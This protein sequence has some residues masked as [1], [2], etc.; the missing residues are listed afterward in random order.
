MSEAQPDAVTKCPFA[1]RWGA[2]GASTRIEHRQ[3]LMV[4][5]AAVIAS[6]RYAPVMD[7]NREGDEMAKRL[8]AA[9]RG[10]QP[11]ISLDNIEGTIGG[12]CL[13]SPKAR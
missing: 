7:M 13:C 5:T 2:P 9:L 8:D 4:D 12:A 3:S 11:I 1:V 10:G 6:G